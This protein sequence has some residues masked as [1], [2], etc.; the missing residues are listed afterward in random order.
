MK[1]IILIFVLIIGL[2]LINNQH[3]NILQSVSAYYQIHDDINILTYATKSYTVL[4]SEYQSN[5][6]RNIE[7][8]DSL[9]NMPNNAWDV[10]DNQDGSVMAWVNNDVLYIAGNGGVYGNEDSSFLFSCYRN[11]ESVD[12]NDCFYTVD[13]KDMS[14]MFFMCQSL[15]SLDLSCFDTSNVTNMYA[16][17]HDCES[18]VGLDVS[19]FDT[20]NV[21]N[22]VLMFNECFSLQDLDIGH[23]NKTNA[24]TSYMFKDT[25]YEK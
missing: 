8:L 13:V 3:K 15:V 19:S 22:M 11:L 4:G 2:I 23:F 25:I 18:L 5:D 24:D 1:K 21:T 20:S 6:I 9:N 14:R 7:F 16:M 10:S 12:F 17:F